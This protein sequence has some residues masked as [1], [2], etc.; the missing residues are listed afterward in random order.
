MPAKLK[1]SLTGGVLGSHQIALTPVDMPISQ[2]A[3]NLIKKSMQE[4]VDA[5]AIH[6][7]E[8]IDIEAGFPIPIRMNL[9]VTHLDLNV[10]VD[11]HFILE[12]DDD[13]DWVPAP[14]SDAAIV[15][16][17]GPVPETPVTPPP[18]TTSDPAVGSAS[19]DAGS[20][21]APEVPV[22]GAAGEGEL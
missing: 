20:T 4:L 1:I 5:K 9:V 7:G 12:V 22:G 11:G 3:A 15:L 13:P 10:A 6:G 8:Q 17:G 2:E 21:D 14:P 16:T 19:T 18:F